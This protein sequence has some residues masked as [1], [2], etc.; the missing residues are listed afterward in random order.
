MTN[1]ETEQVTGIVVNGIHYKVRSGQTILNAL[2]AIGIRI[3]SL[4]RGKPNSKVGRCGVCLVKIGGNTEPQHACTEIIKSDMI[5][6]TESRE[7]NSARRSNLQKIFNKHYS[8]EKCAEC[9]W[10]SDCE[11]HRLAEKLNELIQFAD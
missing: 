3:P 4:C 8:A 1:E 7:L 9:I 6:V 5:I 2:K 11:I 10:D